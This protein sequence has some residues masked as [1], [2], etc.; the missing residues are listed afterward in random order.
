MISSKKIQTILNKAVD[1][2]KIFGATIC[3][4]KDEVTSCFASGN[5]SPDRIYFTASVTKLYT[6]SIILILK[7]TGKLML[8]DKITN[9]LPKEVMAGIHVWK[10]KEYSDSVTI[11]HLLSNTSG[12]A[13]Y[14]EQKKKSGRSIMDELISGAD[15]K[16]EFNDMIS[17][18]KSMMPKFPPG[19]KG[20]AFYSDTGFQLLG[21]IIEIKTGM[22]LQKAYKTYIFDPLNL[23]RSYLY[24]DISDGAP[25]AI[26]YKNNILWMPKMMASFGADGGLVATAEEN[27]VFLKAFFEGKLFSI[28]NFNEMKSWNRI[29]FPFKYG[30]ALALFKFPGTYELIGHPG[31]TGSFAYYCPKK[32]TYITGTINQV[33]RPGLPYKLIM[34]ILKTV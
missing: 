17:I 2:K 6:A 32:K 10:G 12:I 27:M 7:D 19:K 21:K 18:A 24:S 15:I 31:A 3:L 30:M 23:K 28:K 11:R 13:D 26:Y 25:A 20:K 14:F 16:M 22:T 4:S 29:F 33:A 9:I 34:K 1:N 8:D 5:M